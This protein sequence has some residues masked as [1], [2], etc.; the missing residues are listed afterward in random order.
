[1]KTIFNKAIDWKLTKENPA[2]KIK[3]LREPPPIVRY[4]ATDE[5]EKLLEACQKSEAKHLYPIVFVALNTGM[6]LGEILNLK[7]RDVDLPNGY[8]HIEKAKGGK[9]RDIP[10]NSELTNLLRFSIKKP[11]T[12][13]VFCD[14]NGKPFSNINRSWKTAKNK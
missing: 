4:L 9:R 3:M 1:M 12:E 13:Y 10:L 2:S 6:R 8:I 5:I 14:E 7:W 11:N